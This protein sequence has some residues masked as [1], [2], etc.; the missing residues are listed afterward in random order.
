MTNLEKLEKD[1]EELN[2]C[3]CGASLITNNMLKSI[4]MSLAVIADKLTEK[5]GGE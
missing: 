3:A 4:A 1:I 2:K 5:E